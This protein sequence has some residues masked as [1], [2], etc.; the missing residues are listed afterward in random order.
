MVCPERYLPKRFSNVVFVCFLPAQNQEN[1][2]LPL[3]LAVFAGFLARKRGATREVKNKQ[4]QAKTSQKYGKNKPKL[5]FRK[6]GKQNGGPLEGPLCFSHPASSKIEWGGPGHSCIAH[7]PNQ[8][9]KGCASSV[10]VLSATAYALAGNRVEKGRRLGISR[11]VKHHPYGC[12]YLDP[13]ELG[14]AL[15]AALNDLNAARP[16][17]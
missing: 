5:K 10:I 7:R 16:P 11:D 3:V 4:K 6:R 13:T 14:A 1:Q 2:P 17:D 15:L 9:S 8:S 12:S